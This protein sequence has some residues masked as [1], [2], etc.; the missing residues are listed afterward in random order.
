M[1][2]QVEFLDIAFILTVMYSKSENNVLA[3]DRGSV[4]RGTPGEVST[5]GRTPLLYR[6]SLKFKSETERP[7]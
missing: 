4:A 6:P 1:H 2:L 7:E 3:V 5:N